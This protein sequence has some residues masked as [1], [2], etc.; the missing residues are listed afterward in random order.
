MLDMFMIEI[1]RQISTAIEMDRNIRGVNE[2]STCT[3]KWERKGRERERK[4][5]NK[6]RNLEIS[7]NRKK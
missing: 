1:E 5:K 3:Y 6:I 2:G 7:R 4:K